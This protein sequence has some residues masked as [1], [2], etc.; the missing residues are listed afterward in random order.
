M[1]IKVIG[2]VLKLQLFELSD[3]V[4]EKFKNDEEI[5]KS[6]LIPPFI[7][8]N[9][10]FEF[11]EESMKSFPDFSYEDKEGCKEILNILT[12]GW[13]TVYLDGSGEPPEPDQE[14]E[15][16]HTIEGKKYLMLERSCMCGSEDDS[17]F[18]GYIGLIETPEKYDEKMQENPQLWAELREEKRKEL[19]V[20]FT[21][22]VISYQE[23]EHYQISY[24]NKNFED[25]CFAYDHGCNASLFIEDW[26]GRIRDEWHPDWRH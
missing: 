2:D 9:K 22:H 14:E 16:K 6:L 25:F 12:C 24:K 18:P 15:I 1:E 3:E 19:S 26:E 7:K 21:K 17:S 8:N 5:R 13:P 20:K 23:F 4:Y 10:K 11:K